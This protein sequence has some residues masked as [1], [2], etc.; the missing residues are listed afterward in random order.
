V[1]FFVDLLF[2]VRGLG[3]PRLDG[4]R[5]RIPRGA[6][7]FSAREDVCRRR[8]ILPERMT[9]IPMQRRGLD[10]ALVLGVPAV[11][12]GQVGLDARQRPLLVLSEIQ[13]RHSA[14]FQSR[15]ASGMLACS[16]PNHSY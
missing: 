2:L 13:E 10:D 4:F 1:M 16:T 8:A 7:F 3:T 11:K 12:L 15:L 14:N 9:G 6:L 5:L